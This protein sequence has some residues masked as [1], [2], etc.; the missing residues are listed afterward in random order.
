MTLAHLRR[1]WRS[2]PWLAALFLLWTAGAAFAQ[3]Q[4]EE[5]DPPGRVAGL[6]WRQGSVVFAPAG[7]DEWVELPA[8]RPLTTGDRIWSDHGA[9]AELHL[10]AATL[11]LDG[12][13]HLGIS[14]LDDRAAQF[15]LM[16]GSVNARVRELAEGENFE[17]GTPN[18][19]LRATQPGDFRV[20][21]DAEGRQTRVVVH[22]GMAT[23]FGEGGES[24]H[25]GAGQQATFAGRFLA[26]VQGQPYQ[27]DGFAQ[28]AAQRNQAEDQS[29]TARYVPR[30]VV[31]YPQLDANGTW[32]QDAN[33]GAVWYPRVT[34]ADWAP[35]RHGRWSWVDPW[36]WTWIDDAS[37][38]FAP[39]HYGRWALLGSR[40]AWVPGRMVAR[41]VYSPALVSFFGS[42]G[43]VSFSI[44]SGPGVG[45][46]PLAPGEAWWPA[47]RTSPRYVNFANYNINLNRYPRQFQDH[48]HRRHGHAITAVREDDFR[49]GRATR[50][51][52]RPLSPAGLGQARIGAVP[53][54][55]DGRERRE[56]GGN[57]RL[58]VAPRTV[59][60]ALP[61]QAWGQGRQQRD[62][63]GR[64]QR[65]EPRGEVEVPS[66]RQP[67]FVLQPGYV[68]PVPA[69]QPRFVPPVPQQPPRFE[70]QRPAFDDRAVREQQRARQEQWRL[71][72]DAERGAREQQREAWQQQRQG[73]FGAPPQQQPLQPQLRE[74]QALP[75]GPRVERGDRG[76]RGDRGGRGDGRWQRGDDDGRRGGGQPQWRNQGPR[77]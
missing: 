48:V 55:P 30:G 7:E 54:R 18:I 51:H 56:F 46:Y 28:W 29:L 75:I 25:L 31:G 57:A 68:Q 26:Q 8:N 65:F 32:A 13:S 59:A 37:W 43:G 38:G 21:V 15:I 35:Y 64:E 77:P 34:V 19:A 53:A 10:G 12:A 60:P 16:Q 14:A 62:W 67:R 71:Q 70:A 69:P 39:F 20:D 61:G 36:G 2:L 1:P 22:G 74:Q 49:R 27:Q 9:R 17:I 44:G 47:F 23:V 3:P 33:Y 58:Q 41:P 4:E 42:A 5:S 45:W 52:W 24:I 6:T 72:R 40:W 76:D 50:D 63:A 11:H 66:R 73:N